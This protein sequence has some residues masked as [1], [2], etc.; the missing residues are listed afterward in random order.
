M[1]ARDKN[2]RTPLHWATDRGADAAKSL[3]TSQADVNARDN[4][5]ETPLHVAVRAGHKRHYNNHREQRNNVN[6]AWNE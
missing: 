1:N 2:G 3:L 4:Q 6:E 5:R